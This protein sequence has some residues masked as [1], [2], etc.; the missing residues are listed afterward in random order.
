M[1]LNEAHL[2][3]GQEPPHLNSV[4]ETISIRVHDTQNIAYP[5]RIYRYPLL[6]PVR[7]LS[8]PAASLLDF[9]DSIYNSFGCQ[10]TFCYK[11]EHSLIS[12]LLYPPSPPSLKAP[13][14]FLLST[15][16]LSLLLRKWFI[17]FLLNFFL[18]SF[19]NS[20]AQL[21]LSSYPAMFFYPAQCRTIITIHTRSRSD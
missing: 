16:V 11:F 17:S 13:C 18:F 9:A 10:L 20:L 3:L 21:S 4:F 7:G 5:H 12:Q 6:S 19:K 8:E 1:F 2:G 14:L 15:P